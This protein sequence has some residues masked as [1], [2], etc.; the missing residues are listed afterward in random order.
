MLRSK[1]TSTRLLAL[2]VGPLLGALMAACAGPG[3][4]S[5]EPAAVLVSLRNFKSGERFELASESHTDRVTYYSGARQDAARKIQS[6]E[7]MQAFLEE[8]ERQGYGAHARPGRA[9]AIGTSD[10]IRW[11]LEVEGPAGELSWLVGA[12][13][14]PADWADFQRCR[15]VFL[16]LY[17]VTVSYQAVQNASGKEYFEEQRP[18]SSQKPRP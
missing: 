9:P 13:A 8:L 5:K 10:T 11:G 12:N 1:P 2:L 3:A 17:N 4:R 6:D 18:T 7:I 16:Q 15:D 14:S